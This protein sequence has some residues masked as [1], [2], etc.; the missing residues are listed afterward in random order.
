M[1]I[2]FLGAWKAWQRVVKIKRVYDL[3]EASDGFRV[4]VD[5]LWPRGLKKEVAH[6]ACSAK[7]YRLLMNFRSGM[8]LR[9]RRRKEFRRRFKSEL[10]D[11]AKVGIL[12]QL[13]RKGPP[14]DCDLL[15]AGKESVYNNAEVII[16]VFSDRLAA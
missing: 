9:P 3:P 4:L 14:W 10:N 2:A 15:F 12:A 13:S 8:V 6:I 11:P 16:A 1:I 5:R 7:M